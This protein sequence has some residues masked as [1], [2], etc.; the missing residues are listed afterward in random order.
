[1]HSIVVIALLTGTV[2]IG[3][4]RADADGHAAAPTPILAE[5]LRWSGPPNAP[6]LQMAWVLGNERDAGPYVMRVK[7]A[8]GT[9]I[10]PHTHPD[11]RV[12]TVLAGAVYVAFGET[13]DET[14]G[15]AMPIGAVYVLPARVP[16][17]VWTRD[18]EASYQETGVAPTGTTFIKQA[19][20]RGQAP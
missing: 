6:G 11:E 2:V 8:P 7:L 10:P 3:V 1:V 17:Y 20:A 5:Q 18:V 4:A 14:K 12:C 16:H 13:F 15:V 9:R 19:E